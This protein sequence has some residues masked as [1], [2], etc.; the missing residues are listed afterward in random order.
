MEQHTEDQKTIRRYLL[1]ELAEENR[2]QL[3]ESLL[4][5]DQLYEELLIVEDE[6]VD[7]YAAGLLDERERARFE[8]H[9]LATPDRVRKLRFAKAFKKHVA[10]STARES[11]AATNDEPQPASWKQ[12]LPAFLHT[13]NPI[14]SFALA[15][16]LLLIAVVG[17]RQFMHSY[18][19]TSPSNFYAVTL[20]PG[21]VRDAGEMKRVA[22]PSTADGAQ[23]RLELATDDYQSYRAALQTDAGREIFARDSLKSE[24]TGDGKFVVLSLPSKLLT[25]GDYQVK[26]KGATAGGGL[27]EIGSYYFRVTKN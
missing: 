24:T 7:E 10:A 12:W 9:F 17:F 15:T 20:T 11:P 8:S 27:E 5:S 22:I 23:L 6:L 16:A 1:G 18:G 4:T 2:R 25:D 19:D 3:E 14:L 26:L 13:R 21:V